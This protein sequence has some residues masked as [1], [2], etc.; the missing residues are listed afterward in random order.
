MDI[1]GGLTAAKLALDLAKDL[2]QIDRSVDEAAF[3]LKLADLTA[4]LADTQVALS[5]VRVAM[6]DKDAKIRDLEAKLRDA[7]DGEVCPK[8]R[9]GRMILVSTES[10]PYSGLDRFGVEEWH[11]LCNNGQCAFEQDRLHD[12]HKVIGVTVKGR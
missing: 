10:Y 4:A 8:C 2:R 11:Y 1:I 3:R 7:T 9:T 12:P 5:E 6:I